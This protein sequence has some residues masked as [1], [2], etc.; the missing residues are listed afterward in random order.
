MQPKFPGEGSEKGPELNPEEYLLAT[1]KITS[2]RHPHP[3]NIANTERLLIEAESAGMEKDMVGYLRQVAAFLSA[4]IIEDTFTLHREERRKWRDE[5]YVNNPEA[6]LLYEQNGLR[7]NNIVPQLGFIKLF[8]VRALA[9]AGG[10][11]RPFLE[12]IQAKADSFLRE[13]EQ[14]GNEF[15]PYDRQSS[16]ERVAFVEQEIIPF[17]ESSIEIFVGLYK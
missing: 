14:R 1:G 3:E 13:F 9:S 16:A 6:H 10:N 4:P 2:I 15:S 7:K 11:Q 8:A 5:L 12:Q 17:F